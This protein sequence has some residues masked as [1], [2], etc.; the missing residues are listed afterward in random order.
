MSGS[1][2]VLCLSQRK[3]RIRFGK[4]ETGVPV[5][6]LE[7]GTKAERDAYLRGVGDAQGWEEYE[8]LDDGAEQ[9]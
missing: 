4:P 3:L 9:E 6:V 1:L 8:V 2:I 7:F 5:D